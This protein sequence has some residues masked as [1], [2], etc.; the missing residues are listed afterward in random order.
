MGSALYAV[1]AERAYI[2]CLLR[3]PN[4]QKYLGTISENDFFEM[5]GRRC[6]R[7]AKAL[8]AAH[9]VIDFV[10][11]NDTVS[12]LF[13]D[14]QSIA[15]YATKAFQSV[16]NGGNAEYYVNAIRNASLR[17]R[18]VTLAE[19]LTK[20]AGDST[21]D[22]TGIID[23]TREKIREMK[24]VGK[25]WLN[26]SDVVLE[27]YEYLEK[28]SAGELKPL[29]TGIK[30]IDVLSG[31]LFPGEMTIIG[32]RPSVGKTAM[33]LQ[34]AISAADAGAKVCFISVEMSAQQMGNRMLARESGVNGGKLRNGTISES[35]WQ[36]LGA[37]MEINSTRDIS[38]LHGS[39]TIEQIRQDV[40]Q[41]VEDNAC[42]LLIVDYMQL[43]R[44]EHEIA[45]E[46]ER[47]GY[48]SRGFKLMSL[49]LNIP[50]VVL[51]QLRRPD[52][53]R[54]PGCPTMDELRGSGDM[55]QDADNIILMHRPKDDNDTSIA[56][57][58]REEFNALRR[59]GYDY[60][61]FNICKLRQGQIG[62]AS[63]AFDAAHMRY[64]EIDRR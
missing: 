12:K 49:D 60:I 1:E 52:K 57:E 39:A 28:M 17:R 40:A 53:D 44:T 48:V 45:K 62:M 22:V 35:D 7:A 20:Q 25:N 64:I 4:A 50:V 30:A 59:A 18:V 24:T 31:G 32:A 5:Q 46:Y 33:G 26:T 21:A 13:G 42:D 19:E 38:F 2:G 47:I 58:D 63:A 16:P 51:A 56:T 27:S 41:K 43:I 54:K 6:Y 10:S 61:V 11:L 34:L 36:K 37:A 8:A 9:Q 55:E 15:S 14:D 3:S 29:P 23:E